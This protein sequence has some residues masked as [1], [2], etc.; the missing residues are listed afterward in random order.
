M[1]KNRKRAR[2][3]LY[4]FMV[5]MAVL[6]G[7]LLYIQIFCHEELAQAATVQYG[8]NVEGLDTRGLIL[9]RNNRLITGGKKRY[10]YIIDTKKV[11]DSCKSALETLGAEEA[12]SCSKKYTVFCGEKNP[13]E[14]TDFLRNAYG[15]YI[16]RT[17]GRYGD[18]QPACHLV[19][20][21][22][23]AE[24]K[25]VS[26]LELMFEDRLRAGKGKLCLYADAG[27]NIIKGI[28]PKND[29]DEIIRNSVVTTIDLSL[30]KKCESLLAGSSACVVCDAV[31]GEIYAMASSPVFNPNRIEDYLGSGDD[32]LI[33]KVVQGGYPPGS[34]FKIIT[35]AAALESGISPET[36][37]E[38]SGYVCEGDRRIMCST[39]DED[40]HGMINMTEAMAV[41]CNSY[42]IEL[43]KIIGREKIIQMARRFGMG[44]SVLCDFPEETSG[45]LPSE[46][47]S[48][49]S[50][51]ANI[52][53]G[54]GELLVT[55]LQ[56]LQAVSIIASGGIRHPLAITAESSL[57]ASGQIT[58]SSHSDI[59]ENNSVFEGTRV[60]S[61]ETAECIE[62]ML[63][64]VMDRGTGASELRHSC[65]WGKTGT[66]EAQGM[67]NCWFAG[68]CEAGKKRFAVV[69]FV[70]NGISGS[71]S[72]LPVFDEIAE[73]IT[74][75]YS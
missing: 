45:N 53:I 50:D 2:I 6:A 34:V 30:Q 71:A 44:S 32:C 70:E 27:G 58:T 63:K 22:N 21:L 20:Y 12:A 68:Y 60:I 65:T 43:G 73:Y 36:E 33:N 74:D 14:L 4:C 61:S 46:S 10:Y 23:E 18:V 57:E 55:P 51:T 42:F 59:Q 48:Y 7:R 8:I 75:C 64:A 29:S 72:A 17:A 19:G 56:L 37:I 66:A 11:D 26:G 9:D 1:E 24:K 49:I 69:V 54:Q 5:L 3:P 25:G 62:K 16:F 52:S 41:S 40:G 39:A 28:S 15:A 47:Q 35:A 38:C 67:N 13:A 31:T